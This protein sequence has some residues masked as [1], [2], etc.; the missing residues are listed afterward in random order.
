MRKFAIIKRVAF[1]VILFALKN[2]GRHFVCATYTPCS[3]NY[4]K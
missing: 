1:G 3:K 4:E 2:S